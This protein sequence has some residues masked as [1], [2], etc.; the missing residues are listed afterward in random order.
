VTLCAVYLPMLYLVLRRQRGWTGPIIVKERRRPHRL[1][2]EE[3]EV[4]GSPSEAGG[5]TVTV[6]HR[7]TRLSATESGPTRQSAERKAQDRLA[8]IVAE[9]RRRKKHA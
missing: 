2:D 4:N 1:P 7:P 9:E 6:T 8:A 3:L 5:A